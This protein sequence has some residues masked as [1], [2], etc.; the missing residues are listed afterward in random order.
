M[1]LYVAEPHTFA[2]R[3]LRKQAYLSQD[4]VL[5]FPVRQRQDTPPEV[6][7]IRV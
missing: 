4:G 1:R 3:N 7:A 2:A 6:L 5:D